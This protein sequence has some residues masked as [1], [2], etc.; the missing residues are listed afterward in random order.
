MNNPVED[1]DNLIDSLTSLKRA[2]NKFNRNSYIVKIHN[3]ID[4]DGFKLFIFNTTKKDFN[5]L[6]KKQKCIL[7]PFYNPHYDDVDM[8]IGIYLH[9]IKP[10]TI[11][12]LILIIN[13]IFECLNPETPKRVNFKNIVN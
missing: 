4:N 2:I 6:T 9:K 12:D 7:D 1:I 10:K 5:K 8:Y 13:R 11:K 3:E